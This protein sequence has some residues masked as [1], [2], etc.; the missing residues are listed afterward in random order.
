MKKT[1]AICGREFEPHV[2]NQI[3]CSQ[4]CRYKNQQHSNHQSYLRN[5]EKCLARAKRQYFAMSEEEYQRRLR[6][7][8]EQRRA[9]KG[10]SKNG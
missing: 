1:C 3:T 6:D 8:R 5:R 2:Y 7:K 4:E 9:L 10:E